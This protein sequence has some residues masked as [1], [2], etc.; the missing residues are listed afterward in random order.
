MCAQQ[1]TTQQPPE[2]PPT[3]SS[4]GFVARCKYG[5]L[6][7]FLYAWA[8]CFSLKGLYLLGKTFGTLEWAVNH[9]RRRKFRRYMEQLFGQPYNQ[10]DSQAMK[11]ACRRLCIRT[12][13]DKLF[14]LIF[15]K[16][17]R[18]KIFRRI[19]FPRQAVLDEGLSRGNGAYVCLSHVGSHH[20]VGL[21][22][23]LLGYK[24]AGVRDAS[25]GPLRRYIQACYAATFPEFR[26]LRLLY[27]DT[28]PRDIYRCFQEGFVLGSAMDIGRQRDTRLKTV[29]VRFMG[30]EREFLL[31]PIQIAIRCK[32]PIYQGFIVSRPNFHYELQLIG[33]LAE[34]ETLDASQE[35][36]QQLM[37]QYADNIAAHLEEHPDH[38]SRV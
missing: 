9:K 17:P 24:V 1:T 11:G 10:I 23:A 13:C 21:L 26:R 18:D 2:S 31:G 29:P 37:Q 12:R 30:Q 32:A 16:L 25:E 35:S 8:R 22:M 6:R 7:G 27:A 20:V 15:D 5:L 38:T 33:P 4:A 19:H 14:Y 28:F 34:P 36:I 3:Q